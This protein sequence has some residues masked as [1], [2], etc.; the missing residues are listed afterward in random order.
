MVV[1][2]Y[3]LAV[4]METS[5]IPSIYIV[6][7]LLPFIS[8]FAPA[9]SFPHRY[10]LAFI[11][12]VALI[13]VLLSRLNRMEQRYRESVITMTLI[14][15]TIV[16]THPYFSTYIVLALLVYGVELLITMAKN[17]LSSRSWIIIM[18]ISIAVIYAIHI[19]YIADPIMLRE[20]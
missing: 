18:F 9:P 3:Y 11:L 6:F 8:R 7:L 15:A 1:I 17:T 2:L 14:L 12:S 10:Q 19:V 16:F 20:T 5:Q 13:G 4:Q